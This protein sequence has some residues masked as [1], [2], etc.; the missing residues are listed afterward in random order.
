MKRMVAGLLYDEKTEMAVFVRKCRGPRFMAGKLN[1]PG[2]KVEENETPIQA[3][4]REFHEETGV[5][6]AETDW[7]HSVT[8][9][10]ED[11]EVE[12][13]VT[14]GDAGKA[15]TTTDERIERHDAWNMPG[16]VL[17]NLRWIVPLCLDAFVERPVVVRDRYP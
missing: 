2:G 16:D 5:K 8:L 4:V 13:F 7:V 11:F 9:S 14:R 17:P 10:G 15:E 3:M 1:L 12:F 6:T